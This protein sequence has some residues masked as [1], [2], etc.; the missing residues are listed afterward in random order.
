MFKI[1]SQNTSDLKIGITGSTGTLGA[2]L[3]QL[4]NAKGLHV[5]A[6]VRTI[7]PDQQSNAYITFHQGDITDKS[8]LINFV[9][10]IDVCVHLAAL[11]GI[12][13][14][15]DYMLTNVSGTNSLC[16]VILEYNSSCRLIHCSSLASLR[17]NNGMK[18][19]HT[20]YA[21]SKKMADDLI[22][23]YS[24]EQNLQSTI[25]YPGLIYGPGDHLFVPTAIKNIISRKFILLSG[26]EKNAP[27]IY[28]HDL[29]ELLHQ[30]IL[31]ESSVHK[32]FVA[33]GPG[34]AGIHEFFNT[35]ARKLGSRERKLILPKLPFL[36]CAIFLESLY[37]M[38]RIKKAPI[39][40]RR[41]VDILS[42]NIDAKEF[43]FDKIP[44]WSPKVNLDEG[45][46]HFFKWYYKRETNL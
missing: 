37:K 28:I 2:Q 26:G 24:K 42:I 40:S 30:L 35:L 44:N 5:H 41:I 23:K 43:Q 1:M 31:D 7:P 32:K 20:H 36:A 8:S 14:M 29:C 13:S 38:L 27:L 39:L 46:D 22:E 34:N 6:L 17:L 15:K 12:E 33:V 25:I 11:V 45:L 9:K 16:E 18:L 4:L 19:E 21:L 10:E 3:I